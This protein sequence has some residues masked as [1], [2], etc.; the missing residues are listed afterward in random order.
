MLKESLISQQVVIAYLTIC[1][2]GA[3]E[4]LKL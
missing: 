1:L 2:P 3:R 4:D